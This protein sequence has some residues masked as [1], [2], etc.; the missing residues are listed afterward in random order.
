M[1]THIV[2]FKLKDGSAEN[3]ANT[4]QVLRDMEGKIE[5]LK[6]IEVGIDVLHSERSY[7][8]ALITKFDSMEALEQY[9]VHPVHKKVIEHML[10][11]REASVSVD[12]ES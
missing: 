12:F 3:V 2:F 11:V 1:L 4:A 10:Q 7:H 9:Q 8:I 5:V 6:S